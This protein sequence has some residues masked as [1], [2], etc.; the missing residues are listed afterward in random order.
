MSKKDSKPKFYVVWVGF[1]PGV[2]KTWEACRQQV[3]GYVGAKH[4]AFPSLE[5]ARQAYAA[6]PV[7]GA[8]LASS[9]QPMH[10]GT[11]AVEKPLGN[12]IAVDAACSGNPGRM[13][14]R[15]VF[16]E[17]GTELFRSPV[18]EMA[19][20]NIGEFLAIVHALAWQKQKKLKLP[21]YTDSALAIKWV[22]KGVANSKLPLNEKTN[23]LFAVIQ[24]AEKWLKENP[25]EVPLLKWDTARWGEIPADFGRK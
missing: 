7:E 18:W 3:H 14:Y 10:A 16:I 2:Y 20:N 19:T 11:D 23:D 8:K 13:E 6:G 9:V 17:T 1:Q 25:I 21:V 24:R 15:G 12:A 22:R 4:K 5:L